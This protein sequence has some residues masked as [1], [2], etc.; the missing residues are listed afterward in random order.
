V[1][2]RVRVRGQ[3][4]ADLRE[5]AEDV[6]SE[7]HDHRDDHAARRVGEDGHPHEPGEAVQHRAVLLDVLV[8]DHKGAREGDR[9]R[10]DAKLRVAHLGRVRR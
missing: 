4:E 10:E 5:V 6:A 7:L 2:A 1:K 8:V 9:N 3:Y